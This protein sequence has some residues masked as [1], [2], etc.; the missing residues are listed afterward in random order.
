M[1]ATRSHS[2]AIGSST[3]AEKLAPGATDE[4]SEENILPQLMGNQDADSISTDDDIRLINV[5]K[6]E[7]SNSCINALTDTIEKGNKYV[8][9]EIEKNTRAVRCLEKA[10]REQTHA[11]QAQAEAGKI[12]TAV[13]KDIKEEI[14]QFVLYY[15]GNIREERHREVSAKSTNLKRKRSPSPDKENVLKSVVKKMPRHRNN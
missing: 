11:I 7:A 9:E 15:R 12:Q 1:S 8:R 3:F 10:V 4:P 14:H 6:D 2:P 5:K 13:L